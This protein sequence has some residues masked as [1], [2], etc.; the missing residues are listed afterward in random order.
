SSVEPKTCPSDVPRNSRLMSCGS[1]SIVMT[2]PP[3]GPTCRQVCAGAAVAA[4]KA[5]DTTPTHLDFIG[6]PF[7]QSAEALTIPESREIPG[8]K[9]L[10]NCTDFVPSSPASQYWKPLESPPRRFRPLQL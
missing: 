7:S 1:A 9:L 8:I 3:G 4:S 2:V 10:S 6:M 5:A